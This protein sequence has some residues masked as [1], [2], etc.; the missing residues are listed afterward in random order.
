M[1]GIE[2]LKKKGLLRA[3]SD[4]RFRIKRIPFGLADLDK[5]TNGGV[6]RGRITILTGNYSCG[7]TFLTQL[8]VKHAIGLGCTTALVDA[9]RSFDPN[10]WEQVGIDIGQMMVHQPNDGEQAVDMMAD[11]IR[12]SVDVVVLDSLAGLVPMEL[13]KEAKHKSVAPQARLIN[14]LMQIVLTIG[15]PSAVVC[16]NQLRS[17]LG[18]NFP[19]DT[20]PGGKGQEF[21]ASLIVRVHREGWIE[22]QGR[23]VGF[24][25]RVVVRKSK[26]G[27][28]F[29]ECILPFLFRGE[30]DELSLLV[31]RSL[32]ADL[33]T[34]SGPWY[35]ILGG[36]NM[37]GRNT[38]IEKI[39]TDSE[40]RRRLE[41][42]LE[43]RASDDPSL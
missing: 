15:S 30:I 21:F 17:G 13:L 42:S 27:T 2:E 5:I 38:V 16:T 35:S 22:E 34:Q 36:D 26:V 11:L 14:R 32:E 43:G 28:P 19:T 23:R 25:M 33:I 4:E 7:K 1:A 39:A 6:P 31:E 40:L 9:E 12:E 37:M 10:W 18:G 41:E 24:N 3:G 29:Q 20:M 8:L